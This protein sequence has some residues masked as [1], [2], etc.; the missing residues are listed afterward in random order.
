[1][2]RPGIPS[3]ATRELPMPNISTITSLNQAH[4][5]LLHCWNQLARFVRECVAGPL[6]PP[7]V[8]ALEERRQHFSA[9]LNQWENAFKQFLCITRASMDSEQLTL[10][11]VLKANHL[12]CYIMTSIAGRP[13]TVADTFEAEFRAIVDL[14]GAVFYARSLSPRPP[15]AVEPIA[16]GLD[17]QSPLHVVAAQCRNT[18]IS[19]R[20]REMILHQCR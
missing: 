12:C 17:V 13:P 18:D 7:A 4:A 11:R 3:P 5:T 20:A 1:M 6:P 8:T 2:Y 14:C 9:W 10:S 16:A 19:N 15:P